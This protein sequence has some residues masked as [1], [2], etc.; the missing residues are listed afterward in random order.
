MDRVTSA[1]H[2]LASVGV[3]PLGAV[4]SGTREEAY[5]IAIESEEGKALP[6]LVDIGG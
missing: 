4:I 6:S 1:R 2:R 5:G 3:Q